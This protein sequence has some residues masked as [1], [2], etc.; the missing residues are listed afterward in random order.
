MCPLLVSCVYPPE[1]LAERGAANLANL[2]AL[3]FDTVSLSLDPQLWKRLMREGFFR[4]GNWARSTEMALYAIPIHVAIACHI[5]LIFYGENPA[6]TIGEKHGKLDGDASQL[7]QGNTIRGGPGQLM[8]PDVTPQQAHFYYYPPDEDM[9]YAHLRLVYLGYYIRDWY[10]FRNAEIAIAHGL[11]TRK[12]P[13]EMTGDL[14]GVSALDEDFR[15][16]NQMIKFVK[17]GFGH[18]TDQVIEAMHQGRMTRE[19]GLELVRKYDGKCDRS[20]VLRYCRYLGIT[21]EEFWKVVES[22]RGQDAWVKR[23]CGEWVLNVNTLEAK[24]R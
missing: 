6:W 18:V 24:S 9:D 15:I 1:Q 5:P 13:P 4:F 19:E 14:W 22:F 7:K 8:P 10:G 16:V 11:Q 12:E 3:G 20:Y 17:F 21:E 23:A 2:I